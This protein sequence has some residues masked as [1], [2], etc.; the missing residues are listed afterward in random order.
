M[1]RS[2]L[3]VVVSSI[4]ALAAAGCRSDSS[5]AGGGNG[6][7]TGD[8]VVAAASSL[9]QAFTTYGEAFDGATARFSFAGSDMLAAQLRQGVKPDVF[10]AANTKLPEELFAAGL[11]HKPT[12]FARNRL[13]LAVPAGS[14][15]VRSLDDLA[16][17]GVTIAAG[18]ASVPVGA[19]TRQVL[20]RLGARRSDAILANVRSSEPDV[21]GVVGKLTQRAVDAGFVYITDVRAA[22]GRLE[23]IELSSGLRP[24]VDY[25]V[26]VVQGAPH[27]AQARAFVTGLLTGAGQRALRAAGFQPPPG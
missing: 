2:R 15:K 17:A 18:S 11:V 1:I 22:G 12:V 16:G 8:V 14:R 19:Y 6:S 20:A 7:S 25:G 21:A 13:V 27:A 26:A 4:L 23:A 5:G 24:Q 9:K 10:A 3:A